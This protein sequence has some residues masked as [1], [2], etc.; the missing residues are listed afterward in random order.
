MRLLWLKAENFRNLACAELTP[1]RELTVLCGDNGQGK[2]NLLEAIWLLT[3]GRSFR[4]GRDAELIRRGCPFAVVEAVTERADGTQNRV[5]I[6]IGGPESEKPGRCARVNGA[7]RG[8]EIGR[9]H[10]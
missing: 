6:T 10:V 5:R 4:G 7:D 2:T 3:G 8:R 9:A 1:G